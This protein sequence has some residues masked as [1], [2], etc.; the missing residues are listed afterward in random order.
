MGSGETE[1]R[2]LDDFYWIASERDMPMLKDY[3]VTQLQYDQFIY[4][5]TGKKPTDSKL[6]WA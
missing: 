5:T 2:N 6:R 1:V 4:W 3:A